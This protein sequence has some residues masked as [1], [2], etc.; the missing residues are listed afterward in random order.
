VVVRG[1]G[2]AFCAGPDVQELADLSGDPIRLRPVRPVWLRAINGLEELPQPTI[3]RI[4]GRCIGAGTEIALACDLRVMSTDATVALAETRL[5][6]IPD[7]GGRSR[8]PAL[9]GLGRAKEIIMTARAVDADEALR[10]GLANRIAPP[11][12][13]RRRSRR[14][15][16]RVAGHRSAAVGAA[17]RVLD[18]SA[19]PALP[20]VQE[21]E[22]TT[23]DMLIRTDEFRERR[24]AA[25]H[26]EPG[27]AA[28]TPRAG[29]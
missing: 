1:A 27:R 22:G 14:T 5:G 25:A 29:R 19:K 20:A 17:K 10:I 15:D 26:P 2:R 13:P 9:V 23:Q 3:A 4:H 6:I 21:P 18:T 12:R 11:G 28:P 8:L 16:R 24:R 7:L